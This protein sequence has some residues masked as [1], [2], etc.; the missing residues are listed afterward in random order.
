MGMKRIFFSFYLF[1]LLAILLLGFGFSPALE[2]ALEKHFQQR[3]AEYYGNVVEGFFHII[4]SDLEAL[5]RDRWKEAVSA[6]QEHFTF[7]LSVEA[8]D[9][10]D[11][12]AEERSMLASG[13]I[14]VK[15]DGDL[16]RHQIGGSGMVLTM[17]P[18]PEFDD[19]VW[20]LE[21]VVYAVIFLLMALLSLVWAAPFARKL[22]GI[23]SAAVAFG[24][25]QF[26]VRASVPARSALA[27]MAEAFNRMADRIQEL[28]TAQKELTHAVS[29][30]LRTPVARL[31]FGMEMMASAEDRKEQERQMEG[32]RRDVDELDVLVT[33]MLTY[34]RFDREHFQPKMAS[35]DLAQWLEQLT[36]AVTHELGT[37]SINCRINLPN[38]RMQSRVN[39]RYLKRAVRNLLQ[40]AHR[41]AKTRIHVTLEA[42]NGE[43]R[44]HVDD[45]GPGVLDKDR[46][47][48]FE[49]FVRLDHSRDRES[50]G[51]G[52]GLAIVHRIA[53]WHG[54]GVEAT[55]A[56]IGGARFTLHWPGCDAH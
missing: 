45:D 50:G 43:C 37:P 32:M 52:L 8:M 7:P 18:L 35:V 25:G 21:V 46:K 56:P 42:V 41:Y 38:P 10:L 6:I 2:M 54:G 55:D 19:D 12:S 13:G 44:I 27:P 49:P 34:A 22:N 15:G 48:V 23:S 20:M 5:P 29:H 16:F 33:E 1:V 53:E 17:G 4:E 26:D 31:R 11:L 36:D 9:L 14:F 24:N 51:H 40:N 47:R 30:E 39:P 3:V 28:M